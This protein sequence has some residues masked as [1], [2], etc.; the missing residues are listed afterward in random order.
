MTDANAASEPLANL[1]L[2]EVTGER[3]R[4]VTDR[5]HCETQRLYICVSSKTELKKRQKQRMLEEKRAE[6][7]AKAP[8]PL[9]AAQK[10]KPEDEVELTP[11][12]KQPS[13]ERSPFIVTDCH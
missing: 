10:K 3:V 2:D 7:A 8:N 1:H 12:V 5:L 9:V 11:N 4:Y 6:K 13:P